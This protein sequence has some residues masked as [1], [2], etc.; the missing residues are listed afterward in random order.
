MSFL[1]VLQ[2]GGLLDY[3]HNCIHVF[4]LEVALVARITPG[5]FVCNLALHKVRA[6]PVHR[7][8]VVVAQRRELDVLHFLCHFHAVDA[9][10]DEMS[11]HAILQAG[12]L[13]DY[14]HN[15][16]HVFVLEVALVARITLGAFVCNPAL[17]KVRA[18]PFHRCTVFVVSHCN[19]LPGS[20]FACRAA[21]GGVGGGA[22]LGAGGRGGH[23]G[24]AGHS[25]RSGRIAVGTPD[26]SIGGL[27]VLCKGKGHMGSVL[28][29]KVMVRRSRVHKCAFLRSAAGTCNPVAFTL[30]YAGGFFQF[31][32]RQV[33]DFLCFG[34]AAPCTLI[35]RH[36]RWLI[37]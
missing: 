37:S 30:F 35:D 28:L 2:A 9:G 5:A 31:H 6:D 4:V 32:I 22:H 16:I 25:F 19:I 3:L 36:C 10:R 33:G 20:G 29:G 34:L 14:L 26:G 1:A 17:H 15:C 13:L 23:L 24:G 8:T 7:C 12:G 21:G 11:F 27:A 18:D